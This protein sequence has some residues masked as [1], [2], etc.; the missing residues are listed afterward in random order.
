MRACLHRQTNGLLYLI[1]AP[2][3]PP[4]PINPLLTCNGSTHIDLRRV[5]PSRVL[6][7]AICVQVCNCTR[8]RVCVCVCL[9]VCVCAC[10][11]QP[12]CRLTACNNNSTTVIW[13][14]NTG[15]QTKRRKM[16]RH[17]TAHLHYMPI[18]LAMRR[19]RNAHLHYMPS[20]EEAPNS[21]SKIQIW[22]I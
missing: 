11:A 20:H 2:S 9:C 15:Q 6:N 21:T 12:G 17:R 1:P 8:A 14:G 4:I 22:N 18:F 13:K 10:E 7:P 16:R 19:H 5:Y 3:H